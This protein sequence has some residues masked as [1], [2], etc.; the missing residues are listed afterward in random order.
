MSGALAGLRV[1]IV[2]DSRPM[3][4]FIDR[5]LTLAGADVDAAES[6]EQ[7]LALGLGGGYDAI[8]LDIEMPGLDGLTVAGRLR[9]AG[10]PARLLA[11]T[12]HGRPEA[13][14]R[15]L[16][17]GFDDVIA[18][19]FGQRELSLALAGKGPLDA[20]QCKSRGTASSKPPA[21][22]SEVLLR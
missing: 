10:V 4:V 16:G 1:L 20:P 8:L 14:Q 17:G 13:R 7:G 21:N 18:K 15:F 6:G 2:D 11:V 22:S 19:P 3:R 12:A 5:L 9:A